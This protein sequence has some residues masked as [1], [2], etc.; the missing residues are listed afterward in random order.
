MMS[1]SM[2]QSLSPQQV[3]VQEDSFASCLPGLDRF[4]HS[5]LGREAV[6][7]LAIP[8]AD[9]GAFR[10]LVDYLLCRVY[11]V[12]LAPC[13]IHYAA[14]DAGDENSGRL[15]LRNI[16]TPSYRKRLSTGIISMLMLA[17]RVSRMS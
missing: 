7:L 12:H 13:L 6:A 16:T 14:I 5:K 15:A 10:S 2:C 1:M 4:L 11:P 8:P 9:L 17:V 3:Q